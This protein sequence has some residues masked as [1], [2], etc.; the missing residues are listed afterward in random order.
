MAL[1]KE[2]IESL[3]AMVASVKPDTMECDGCLEHLAELVDCELSGL[4]I[5][6]ALR[7]V[8][9][10]ID[11]CPCCDDEHAALLEGLRAIDESDTS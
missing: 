8:Q 4:E 7:Q 1:S 11:Q 10:H 3:L 9:R 2:Q 6:E 5:P